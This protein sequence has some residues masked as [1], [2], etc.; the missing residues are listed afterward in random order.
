M[1]GFVG[2]TPRIS[3][4]YFGIKGKGCFRFARGPS[5]Q[6]AQ[7]IIECNRR[8]QETRESLRSAGVHGHRDTK[9]A[10]DELTKPLIQGAVFPFKRAPKTPVPVARTE[11]LKRGFFPPDAVAVAGN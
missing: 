3:A 5:V 10:I 8:F 6:S 9:V 4:T 2:P 1:F 7:H 11:R